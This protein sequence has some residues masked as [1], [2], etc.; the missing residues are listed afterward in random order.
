MACYLPMLCCLVFTEVSGVSSSRSA[1]GPER[2]QS[3]D[4]FPKDCCEHDR[5]SGECGRRD[6]VNTTKPKPSGREARR[7][8]YKSP[9]SF[10]ELHSPCCADRCFSHPGLHED[11]QSLGGSSVTSFLTGV[12]SNQPLGPR[13]PARRS[14]RSGSVRRLAIITWLTN[15]AI[16]PCST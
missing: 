5:V 14:T 4:C 1:T 9:Y 3:C 15:Q 6:W 12:T 2:V 13:P 8:R 10:T 16:E 7:P 11:L